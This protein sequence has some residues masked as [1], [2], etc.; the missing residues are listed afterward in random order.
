VRHI[1]VKLHRTAD[2]SATM[3]AMRGWLDDHGCEPSR[4]T[5][6]RSPGWLIIRVGFKED[7]DA[8]AFK[9]RFGGS[10]EAPARDAMDR[11]CWWRLMAE[12][13]RTE[14][15]GFASASA[16]DTMLFAARAL[17]RMAN[18]LERRLDRE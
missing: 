6:D 5:C 2:L 10:E 16:R 15:D 7:D 8:E 4:F 14:A 17:D 11:V 3:N 13:I 18:D 1:L 12:E 9:S